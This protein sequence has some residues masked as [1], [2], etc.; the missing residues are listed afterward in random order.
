MFKPYHGKQIMRKDIYKVSDNEFV[1]VI[2]DDAFMLEVQKNEAHLNGKVSSDLRSHWVNWG[3]GDGEEE[4]AW[5]APKTVRSAP[6][7]TLTHPHPTP[8][9]LGDTISIAGSS[10]CH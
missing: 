4:N 8:W 10:S 2:L 9:D 1:H 6:T 5:P 7:T 3:S